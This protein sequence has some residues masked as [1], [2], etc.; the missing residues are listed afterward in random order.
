MLHLTAL[1]KIRRSLS[2]NFRIAAKLFRTRVSYRLF[3]CVFFFFLFFIAKTHVHDRT[4]LG[5]FTRR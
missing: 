2:N 3:P 5:Y 1:A 4:R